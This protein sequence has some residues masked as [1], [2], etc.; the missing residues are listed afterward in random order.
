VRDADGFRYLLAANSSIDPAAV[1]FSG[2]LF[3]DGEVEVIGEG[4]TVPARAGAIHDAFKGLD[5][6]LYRGRKPGL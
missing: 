1:T 4:R 5:V 6:H 2:T 3:A